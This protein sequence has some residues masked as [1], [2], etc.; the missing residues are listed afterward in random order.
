MTSS[1]RGLFAI[2]SMLIKMIDHGR[3]DYWVKSIQ[4]FKIMFELR[5]FLQYKKTVRVEREKKEKTMR[6]ISFGIA[7]SLKQVRAKNGNSTLIQSKV[8]LQATANLLK[9]GAAYR[10]MK[11]IEIFTTQAARVLKLNHL[12]FQIKSFGISIVHRW[13]RH[14]AVKKNMRSAFLDYIRLTVQKLRMFGYLNDESEGLFD[15]N[16][17]A[18]IFEC[19]FNGKLDSFLRDKLSRLAKSVSHRRIGSRQKEEILNR[20]QHVTRFEVLR[21]QAKTGEAAELTEAV[22]L[23]Y[24][25][26][27]FSTEM[28]DTRLKVQV[29]NEGLMFD[30]VRFASEEEE[31]RDIFHYVVSFK[32]ALTR[33]FFVSLVLTLSELNI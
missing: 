29:A 32:L 16:R 3:T 33:E 9:E 26:R 6:I 25:R 10:A 4:F 2:E 11:A 5:K 13:K 18:M 7:R 27:K 28:A 31:K 23:N 12:V 17:L 15:H 19:I 30:A 22:Y 1:F 20:Y 14:V 21:D 24:S 8:Q